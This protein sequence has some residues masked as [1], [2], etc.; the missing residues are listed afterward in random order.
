MA[1]HSLGRARPSHL[2]LVRDSQRPIRSPIA[3]LNYS[4]AGM[5]PRLTPDDL[6]SRDEPTGHPMP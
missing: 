2:Q 3:G 1:R 6:A 4:Q 5:R